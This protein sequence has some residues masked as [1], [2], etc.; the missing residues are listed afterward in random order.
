MNRLRAVFIPRPDRRAR[1]EQQAG[2][3]HRWLREPRHLVQGAPPRVLQAS[4]RAPP[5]PGAPPPPRP[6]GKLPAVVSP[7]PVE[8]SASVALPETET[9]LPMNGRRSSTRTPKGL[10]FAAIHRA[11]SSDSSLPTCPL[12]RPEAAR[13]NAAG[14]YALM[15]PTGEALGRALAPRRDQAAIGA[16]AC[17]SSPVSVGQPRTRPRR[18]RRGRSTAFPGPGPLS[19]RG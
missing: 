9:T 16:R 6:L 12:V 18:V 1:L 15:C 8:F 14:R 17:T 2:D 19:Q 10:S 4:P 7:Q 13:V 5:W 11:R 3:R